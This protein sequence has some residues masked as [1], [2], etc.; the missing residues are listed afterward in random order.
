LSG[1]PGQLLSFDEVFVNGIAE[2][3]EIYFKLQFLFD[4]IELITYMTDDLVWV[5][6]DE[7][8]PADIVW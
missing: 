8:C 3:E 1:V 7:F 4:S 6:G 2:T 5:E